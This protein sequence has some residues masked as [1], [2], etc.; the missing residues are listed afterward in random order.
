MTCMTPPRPKN[1]FSKMVIMAQL[2]YK[3]SES[4]FNGRSFHALLSLDLKPFTEFDSTT[5]VGRLFQ[6][7][8][9]Q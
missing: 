8:A 5:D 3:Q 2:N 9:V 7:F 6:S 4:N 1:S